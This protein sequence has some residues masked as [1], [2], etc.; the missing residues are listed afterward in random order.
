MAGVTVVL[1]TQ[2]WLDWLVFDDPSVGRLREAHAA[3]RVEIAIDEACEAELVRV[4]AYDLGK[5]SLQPDA[6]ARCLERCRSAARRVPGAGAADLPKCRDP[7]DQ[8]FLELAAGCGAQI[9]VSK[10]RAVLALAPRVSQFRILAP[11]DCGDL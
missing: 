9:L 8:K 4:L 10:D 1:D 6:Q 2:V 3:G 11:D 5:Y 7:D